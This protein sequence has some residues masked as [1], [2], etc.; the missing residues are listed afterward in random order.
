VNNDA[1]FF[2]DI[3]DINQYNVPYAPLYGA[4]LSSPL[5]STAAAAAAAAVGVES[6]T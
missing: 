2:T 5:L 6:A 1:T 3:A 4:L